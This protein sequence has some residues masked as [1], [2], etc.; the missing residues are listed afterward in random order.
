MSQE[1]TRFPTQPK[2]VR[3]SAKSNKDVAL[4]GRGKKGRGEKSADKPLLPP[5]KRHDGDASASP[6]SDP[7]AASEG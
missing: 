2:D 1:R 3:R 4:D 5:H 6:P 7:P